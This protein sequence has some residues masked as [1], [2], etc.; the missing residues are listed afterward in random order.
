MQEDSVS[1]TLAFQQVLP[2]F[3]GL[4]VAWE[5]RKASQIHSK[6][7]RDPEAT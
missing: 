2:L 3:C 4:G 7:S 5:R 6:H 1:L